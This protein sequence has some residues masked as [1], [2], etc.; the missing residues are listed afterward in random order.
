M[1]EENKIKP[2]KQRISGITM[3][4]I[5]TILLSSSYY[6]GIIEGKNNARVELC[7]EIGG[8]YGYNEKTNEKGCFN[9][10]ILEIENNYNLN[11]VYKNPGNTQ[12]EGID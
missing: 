7:K 2:R 10:T 4:I 12:K 3:I 6:F 11:D 1:V 9:A 5:L 8:F